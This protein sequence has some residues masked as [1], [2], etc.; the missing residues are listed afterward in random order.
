MGI[1]N[2]DQTQRALATV[3]TLRN[4][5]HYRALSAAGA[6]KEPAPYVGKERGRVRLL[7]PSDVY[8]EI[9]PADHARWGIE[10]TATTMLPAAADLATGATSAIDAVF[11]FIDQLS[12]MVAFESIQDKAEVLKLNSFSLLRLGNGLPAMIRRLIGFLKTETE[13][14]GTPY[15]EIDTA[16][17]P[18]LWEQALHRS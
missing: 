15:E 18:Q 17:K 1:S 10:Q 13:S 9:D 12:W 3:F 7:I 11:S 4:T 16:A 14:L 6:V 8:E 5:V 2:V